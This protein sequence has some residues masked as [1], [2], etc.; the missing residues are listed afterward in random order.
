LRLAQKSERQNDYAQ[1]TFDAREPP[2]LVD[3]RR[4]A[5]RLR[6]F[7][8]GLPARVARRRSF[9]RRD[10]SLHSDLRRMGGRARYGNSGRTSRA[11]DGQVEIRTFAHAQSRLRSDDDQVYGVVSNKTDLRLRLVWP[12]RVCC[13]SFEWSIRRVSQDHSQS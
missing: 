6:L 9:I 10:A 5:S 4:P 13:L 8:E 7:A 11:D 1:D 12:A 2:D 3:R